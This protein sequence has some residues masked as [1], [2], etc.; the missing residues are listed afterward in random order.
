M[1]ALCAL[2]SS[3]L[4]P[5]AAALVAGC[6]SIPA[7]RP[8]A[9]PAQPAGTVAFAGLATPGLPTRHVFMTHGMGPT[10]I[11][12]DR[13]LHERLTKANYV[14]ESNG[15]WVPV[16]LPRALFVQSEE[17]SCPAS[18]EAPPCR[19][20]FFG[21]YRVTTYKHESRNERLVLY[22]YFWEQSLSQVQE[23]FLANDLEVKRSPLVGDV[24]T[25]IINHGFSDAAAYI[26]PLGGLMRA[27]AEGAICAMIKH[28]ANGAPPP[29]EEACTF[30]T[31]DPARP[32]LAPP[33]FSFITES[34]GSRLIFDT[35]SP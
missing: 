4:I 29:P 6:V 28:A 10:K 20:E 7:G 24:K 31:I 23:A 15:N 1:T 25:D 3:V 30:A 18:S 5:L 8:I 11:D 19:Y 34:L 2:R 14:V 26:G 21:Q 22:S 9:Q 17:H 32:F 27:G 33:K 16:K 35:L 13:F 12:F